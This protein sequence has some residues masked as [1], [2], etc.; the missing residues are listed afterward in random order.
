ME[1]CPGKEQFMQNAIELKGLTKHYGKNRGIEQ[2]S[3]AVKEGDVLSL[4]HI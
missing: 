1:K 3:L 4:I 2:I